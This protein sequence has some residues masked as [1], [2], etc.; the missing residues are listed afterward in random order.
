M[1]KFH[2]IQSLQ[3]SNGEMSIKIDD[4][5]YTFD[6][7]IISKKLYR[8]DRRERENYIISPAGYGISWPTLDEDLSID[9]LLGIKHGPDLKSRE[10][11]VNTN[12]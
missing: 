7:Q 4:K 2:T 12:T 6:L 8:A 9:G 3:F 11:Q 5:S 1:K 10:F